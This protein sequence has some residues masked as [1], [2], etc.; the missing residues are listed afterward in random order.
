MLKFRCEMQRQNQL[1]ARI[2]ESVAFGY[3]GIKSAKGSTAM[4][5]ILD[6][7]RQ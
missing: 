3:S 7:L 1:Q 2:I 5:H 4:R 6:L